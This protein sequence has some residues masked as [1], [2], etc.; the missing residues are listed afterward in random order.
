MNIFSMLKLL[1][2]KVV[3]LLSSATVAGPRQQAWQL[4]NRLTG[5]PPTS[6]VLQQMEM[7]I[8]QGQREQAALTAM[9]NP[10]FYN[11][12]LKNWIKTWTNEDEDNR[13]PFN[14]YVATVIGM[15][16]D[17]IPFDTVLY[18]DH[19]YVL[20]G[21]DDVPAYN[22]NSNDHY[23]VAEERAVDIS[24]HLVRR[25][26]SSTTGV[27]DTA[28]I[29]TTRASG[30]A[31]LSAGTNRRLTRFTFMNFLCRDFEMVSD[32]TTPDIYVRR[33]VERDPGGDSRTYRNNCVG[34]HA[35]QDALGGAFAYFDFR[36]G[37]VVHEPGQ[38]QAKVNLNN[39]FEDGHVVHDATWTNLWAQ[40]SNSTLGWRGAQQGYGAR[41]FG[42]LIARTEAF[43]QCM[44]KRAYELVCLSSPSEEEQ[45]MIREL[46]Q[47]FEQ[48][49]SYNMRD[50]IAKASAQCPGVYQ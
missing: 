7:Y 4:H 43:S 15:I 47:E 1:L 22:P 13:V 50:L 8:A 24:N 30:E 49:G 6:E 33:D 34:C 17:N 26:Q 32:L 3:L 11:V 41:Q 37:R 46:A 2:F 45:M 29:L 42:H 44:A 16:R 28:G 5:V 20:Q 25:S 27:S 14:D 38:V 48:N 18:G 9:E 31:Y 21:V 40:G 19:L 35:G 39:L 36:D 12:T 23:R 10:L